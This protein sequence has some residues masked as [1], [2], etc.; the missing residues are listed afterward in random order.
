V[1]I[2]DHLEGHD[3]LSCHLTLHDEGGDKA[4]LSIVLVIGGNGRVAGEKFLK[5]SI[6]MA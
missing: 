4:S 5:G 6:L 1:L 3:C 2:G